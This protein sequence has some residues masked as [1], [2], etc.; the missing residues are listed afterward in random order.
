LIQRFH[1]AFL[2]QSPAGESSKF[3]V[4]GSNSTVMSL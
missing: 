3:R 2:S 4:Q 1:G